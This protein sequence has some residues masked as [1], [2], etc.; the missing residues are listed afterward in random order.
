M[1]HRCP[2]PGKPNRFQSC[3]SGSSS[4]IEAA[5][6]I[7]DPKESNVVPATAVEAVSGDTI[8]DLLESSDK[9]GGE[10]ALL[11][12]NLLAIHGLFCG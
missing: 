4:V 5:V 11:L 3:Q 8:T 1:P 9:I 12:P 10:L 6:E 7:L 2:D